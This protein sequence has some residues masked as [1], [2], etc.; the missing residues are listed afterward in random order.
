MLDDPTRELD[1][2]RLPGGESLTNQMFADDTG[3]FLTGET[4]K[5]DKAMDI[6]QTFCTASGARMNWNKTVGLRISAHPRPI[7]W[8]S[9]PGIRW[10]QTGQTATYLGFPI[11]FNIVPEEI[12]NKVLLMIT[13][14]LTTWGSHLLSLAGRILIA[15]Q[16]IL[17]SI[18]YLSSCSGVTS[19]AFR[20]TRTAIRNY[21][22]GAKQGRK[23]R[24][25]IK[26]DIVIL[27]M[28]EGGVKI[29]D[30][31]LQSAALLTKLV[32]RGL[33][34]GFEPWKTLLRQFVSNMKLTGNQRWP[35][36]QQWLMNATRAPVNA[37]PLWH[38][39][40]EAFKVT[41]QGLVQGNPSHPKEV[42]RQPLF[43]NGLIRNTEGLPL[44]LAK[45]SA[46][47]TWAINN[48]SA[49]RDIW[50]SDREHW[51]TIH[52]LKQQTKSRLLGSQLSE[53]HAALP[54]TP[55]PFQP[56]AIGEW[57]TTVPTERIFIVYHITDTSEGV[58]RGHRYVRQQSEELI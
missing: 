55:T 45:D 14:G 4:T 3:L 52:Q 51:K 48:T 38:V 57:V 47:S 7:V 43:G 54:W 12:N 11:G 23:T 22:W 49:V 5:L 37:S 46:F 16:V 8:P 13:K 21:I 40:F 20:Q 27:P 33:K 42:L 50:D 28:V 2:L 26:W 29:I 36:S 19:S 9:D 10:L 25:K 18:W 31:Q 17:A 44:G 58:I 6:I 32:A 39:I 35:A 34:P 30:P 15:N 56:P 53:L 1:G 24:A 41:R